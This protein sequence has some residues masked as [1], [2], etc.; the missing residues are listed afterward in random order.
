MN[1]RDEFARA[2]FIADNANLD[3]PQAAKDWDENREHHDYAFAIADGLIAAG[4]RKITPSW[5]PTLV[6]DGVYEYTISSDCDGSSVQH[7][8]RIPGQTYEGR[9]SPWEAYEPKAQA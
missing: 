2:V 8:R 1:E 7:W 3:T 6:N 4:Y 9:P 5:E